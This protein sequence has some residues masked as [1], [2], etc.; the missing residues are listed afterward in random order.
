M[1]RS[2]FKAN[3]PTQMSPVKMAKT[4]STSNPKRTEFFESRAVSAPDQI[5][6][7]YTKYPRDN[8]LS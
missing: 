6:Q 1:Y 7:T 3:P 2:K 5:K 8:I 4:G